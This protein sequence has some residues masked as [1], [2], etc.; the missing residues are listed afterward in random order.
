MF[1]IFQGHRGFVLQGLYLNN[2]TRMDSKKSK[3]GRA[4]SFGGHTSGTSRSKKSR[5]MDDTEQEERDR[6]EAANVLSSL[7]FFAPKS[8]DSISPVS[9]VQAVDHERNFPVTHKMSDPKYGNPTSLSAAPPVQDSKPEIRYLPVARGSGRGPSP[10]PQGGVVLSEQA[11]KFILM[12]LY[13]SLQNRQGKSELQTS[14]NDESRIPSNLPSES[15]IPKSEAARK[16]MSVNINRTSSLPNILHPTN[17]VNRAVAAALR[18][19]I[20]ASARERSQ[21]QSDTIRDTTANLTSKV[22]DRHLA[23]R[24]PVQTGLEKDSV[25]GMKD[26]KSF[27]TLDSDIQNSK[28]MDST[29][30]SLPLKK[31]RV[32]PQQGAR[33]DSPVSVEVVAAP[34]LDYDSQTDV[35]N[36]LRLAQTTQMTSMISETPSHKTYTGI[37]R[38]WD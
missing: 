32:F 26:S 11:N 25:C 35:K 23:N 13:N 10:A 9:T 4:K 15:I 22:P 1:G 5:N 16:V 14:P 3:R 2:T 19:A 8:Q 7:R 29:E 20:P 21:K 36:L 34:H 17:P 18:N 33:S 24:I 37:I 28:K 30:N 31:R 27:V 6:I 12:H 38:V